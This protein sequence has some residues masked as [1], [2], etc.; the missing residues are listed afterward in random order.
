MRVF[1]TLFIASLLSLSVSAKDRTESEM[2]SIAKQ[3][4][5]VSVGNSANRVPARNMVVLSKL[6]TSEQLNV[7]GTKGHGFVV[8]AKD[9]DFAPVLGYSY[10]DYEEGNMPCGLQWWLRQ[11]NQSLLARKAAGLTYQPAV[12]ATNTASNFVKTAWN[13][14]A[15]YNNLCPKIDGQT[16]PTGCIATAMAQIMYY[17]QYPASG[18]GKGAYIVTSST[19]KTPYTCDINSTYAWSKMKP[20]YYASTKDDDNAV[21][22]LM[23]DAGAASDMNY[24]AAGSGTTDFSAAIGFCENF[25]YDSLALKRYGRDFY[26][27]AEWMG[28]IRTELEAKRPILY[29]GQDPVDGGHAFIFD[30]INAEGKVHVN[31]GWSG[32]GNGWYDINV[33]KPTSYPGS[34]HQSGEGFNESQSMV[35]GFKPQETPDDTE[36]NTSLWVSSDY[37]FSVDDNKLQVSLYDAYNYNFRW[38]DGVV[39]IVLE[40]VNDKDDIQTASL[41]DTKNDDMGQIEWGYG[42]SFTDDDN[43][44]VYDLS[45]DF[46]KIAPGSYK[47]YLASKSTEEKT[48]QYVRCVG[49]PVV[50]NLTVASDGTLSVSKADDLTNGIA[51]VVAPV[52]DSSLT[53]AYDLQGRALSTKSLPGQHGVFIVKQGNQVKKILRH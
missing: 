3:L 11:V 48:Y 26:D 5:G 30:G 24:A 20:R 40:N 1:F 14:E 45:E 31:W 22:T 34:G 18:K 52:T 49:G 51:S 44:A 19:D 35:F 15:P 21:A 9:D 4:L 10:T 28:L 8:I 25:R 29:C 17:Y 50:Y 32:A 42:V 7:Y 2:L 36:Q 13:Q 47:L 6:K 41:V 53:K 23:R 12:Y 33:L 46:P 38:F 37:A 39:D 43:P 16:A 27:D